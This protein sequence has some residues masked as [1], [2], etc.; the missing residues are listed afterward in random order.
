MWLLRV[1]YFGTADND[2]HR[3]VIVKTNVFFIDSSGNRFDELLHTNMN[4]RPHID[5]LRDA[6]IN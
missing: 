3:L 6:I 5:N 4:I 2:A 1:K